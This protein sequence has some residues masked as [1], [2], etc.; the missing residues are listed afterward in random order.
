MLYK[1][2]ISGL[3]IVVCGCTNPIIRY[4]MWT[5]HRWE[6]CQG[7][8]LLAWVFWLT[9][10]VINFNQTHN[11]PTVI[12]DQ[13]VKQGEALLGTFFNSNH[14]EFSHLNIIKLPTFL[15]QC[16]CPPSVHIYS[17]VAKTLD[18]ILMTKFWLQWKTPCIQTP[19]NQENPW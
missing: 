16:C 19:T 13:S 4:T 10:T 18:D 2:S 12:K 17:I 6:H 15:L 8:T 9:V 11:R 14:A 5:V 3:V 7:A 1:I